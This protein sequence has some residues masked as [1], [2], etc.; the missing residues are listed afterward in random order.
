MNI[1]GLNVFHAD[2][3][4]CILKNGKIV[5]AIEEERFTR[6]KHFTGFPKN[7]ID[8]CL[9][10]A[11]LNL[12]EI[13]YICVNFNNNYNL[14][15]KLY[16]SIKNLNSLNIYNKLFSLIKKKSLSGLFKKFY[17]YEATNKI[18]YIPHHLAHI[19][20]TFYYQDIEDAIG[21][22]FDGSGDFS[23]VEIYKLEKGKKIEILEKT[24]YPDSIGIFYQAF[25]QF[26]GFKNYGDEY[27]VMG[28]ASYGKPIYKERIKK[29]LKKGKNFFQLDL[30][31]FDFK[32]TIIDYDFDSGTPFFDDLYSNKIEKLFGKPRE[33]NEPIKQIHKD[34]ASSLQVGLEEV[35]LEKIYELKNK[36]KSK[37]LC[38][39]GGCAFNS[40]LNGKIIKYSGFDNVYLSPN[41]GDAGGAAGAALYYAAE[42]KVNIITDCNPYLGTNYSNHYIENNIISKI[43]NFKH[44][45]V[46]KF[47]EFDDLCTATAKILM[48]PNVIG[49][50]QD[51]MEWG[52][53]AL[54]NRSILAN[55]SYETMREIINIKIKRREEFR[56]FAP[57]ILEEKVD[58]Y[59]EVKDNNA[60]SYMGAI[61]DVKDYAKKKIPSVIHVDNTA[62][63]QIVSNQSNLKFYNLIKEFDKLTNIPVLLNTS[64][65]VNEPICE[66]PENA[67][68]VFTKTSMDALIIENWLLL[69]N[70]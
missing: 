26:L 52:P 37:N 41:P 22:S 36:Y 58:D 64:L 7:S 65:N 19:Y 49:W 25:T 42:K 31:Y 10:K 56:P 53:R 66:S 63:V 35:V 43:K 6:I 62:R 51:R 3:S 48:G 1:L 67:L 44:I 27:K 45:K 40:T 38:L 55:P 46:T 70:E 54:G 32:N 8:F 20:S 2:T 9:K 17:N 24:N 13:D 21:F 69:K 29:V 33:I 12:S 28:L 60:A 34:I 68:E 39:S 11:R 30:S 14:R 15:E 57:A 4:A 16:F 5:V 59:F 18:K 47:E 23:T 61:Y 50:F